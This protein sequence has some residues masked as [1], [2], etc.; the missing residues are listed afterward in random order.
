[1]VRTR[2]RSPPMENST[3]DLFAFDELT[4][5]QKEKYI[6]LVEDFDKQVDDRVNE[7]KAK[8]EATMKTIRNDYRVEMF[9]M[10]ARQ[11]SE[12]PLRPLQAV[13]A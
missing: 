8:M 1:M 6:T 10:S 3:S 12:T 4:K 7:I 11:R 9:K 5:E 13:F 2:S